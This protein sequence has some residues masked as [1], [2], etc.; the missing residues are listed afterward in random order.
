M[1]YEYFVT[2]GMDDLLTFP[3]T[4]PF[5][6]TRYY[7]GAKTEETPSPGRERLESEEFDIS[8]KELV[9]A[10]ADAVVDIIER[11]RADGQDF[12]F[13]ESPCYYRLQDDPVF[14]KYKEEF[15]RILDENG[16]PYILAS[17]VDFDSHDAELFQ[18]MNHM[19]AA[20][21]RAYT[22][23]LIRVLK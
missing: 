1:M 23:E 9:Q 7:K 17:D 18:D 20:G 10:Q 16:A 4:E 13:V 15:I 5:Y 14:R 11:C 6:G 22:K 12:I 19:S 2:S 8:D 21:R 3:V